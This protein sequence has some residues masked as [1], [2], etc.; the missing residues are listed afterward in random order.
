MEPA[1]TQFESAFNKRVNIY[2]MNTDDRR[3]PA[4]VQAFF[5]ANP[6]V[7]QSI[8]SARQACEGIPTTVW[9]DSRGTV[10]ETQVGGLDFK[11]LKKYTESAISRSK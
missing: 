10:L 3:P 11:D 4:E 8:Q 6:A 2:M 7:A 1:W 9:I 5:K